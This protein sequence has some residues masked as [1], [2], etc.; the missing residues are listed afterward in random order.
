[1]ILWFV[2]NKSIYQDIEIPVVK[3]VTQ[4]HIKKI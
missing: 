4:I 1:M 2:T 3:N